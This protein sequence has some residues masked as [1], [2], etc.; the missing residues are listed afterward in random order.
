MYNNI[1]QRWLYSTNA[2]DIG[3]LYLIF[4]V[5]SGMIGTAL[6]LLIR[7]EL[8][9]PGVQVLQGD[10]QLFNVI[11]SSH[12]LIM[13][14]FMVMPGLVG[15]FG[16]Y[17]VPVLLGSPDMA[18]PRLNNVSFWLLPPSLILL[19]VSALIES[20]AG[21]GW[22]VYPPLSSIQSHSGGA[23]DLMI[24]SLHLAGV[25]SLLGA[26]NFITTV[27]N[28]RTHGMAYHHMPLFC[29]AILITA[30]LLLLSLPVLA[31][32][33]F[34]SYILCQL[35][36]GLYAGK[37]SCYKILKDNPQETITLVGNLG[38]SETIRPS[39]SIIKSRF[40][41]L[42]PNSGDSKSS[43]PI[44]SHFQYYLAGLIEGDGS[45]V[46][47]AS[48]R[49]KKGRL[50]YP[51]IQIVFGLMDLPLAL[52]I[53]KTLGYGSI[54]RKKGQGAYIFTINSKE[55]LL[56]T[57]LLLNGK[58]KTSKIK[59]LGNL[60][61]WFNSKENLN[62]TLLPL[63][64]TS[65]YSSCWLA[66]FIEA[67][68]HFSLRTTETVKSTKIECKF[69]LSQAKT[70]IYGDSFPIM[71]E[72]SEFLECPLK[73]I[74]ETSIHPQYRVRT[75]NSKS[76]QIIINYL[77]NYPLKGKKYLDYLSWLEIAKVFLKGKVNHQILLP[78][79][80]EIKSQMNDNRTLFTWDH[81]NDF[82]NIE[83]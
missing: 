29:W 23:V 48:L 60:I 13:I 75:L 47:P 12:A 69:E 16:N 83:K 14:F 67:D 19:L 9:A 49:D 3:T 1:L 78:Q 72:I 66:G 17:L 81:L 42:H 71:K 80:K 39:F 50:T 58:L 15:G 70:R 6:S 11:I 30:V 2:K 76:N 56:K 27:M 40:Y 22:T 21:T 64:K 51:S 54:S 43:K 41:S 20:G 73:E 26:I 44:N 45:I 8:A 24:F 65:L 79:A 33:L 82:Y 63:D 35:K 34:I 37:P 57:I 55:G 28:M 61:H 68:G 62:L 53:Q 32:S 38:S 4:A 10:H 18:F 77:E 31:G 52:I 74:R 46:I 59:A 7:I 36:I 5:F 25:S